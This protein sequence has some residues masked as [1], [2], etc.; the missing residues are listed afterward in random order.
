MLPKINRL[1]SDKDFKRVFGSGKAAE[2]PFVRVKFVENQ[3]KETRFGFVVGIKF[4]KKA[5]ARNLTKRRL[6]AAAR[7]L[8]ARAKPGFDIVIWPKPKSVSANYGTILQSL[9]D[10]LNKNNVLFIQ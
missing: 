3:R 6:R 10:V 9:E 5:A 8:L 7:F 2:N 1:R 4:A